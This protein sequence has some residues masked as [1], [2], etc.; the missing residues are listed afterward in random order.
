ESAVRVIMEA[1]GKTSR[2]LTEGL[3][4]L[5]RSGGAWQLAAAATP[6]FIR[7]RRVRFRSAGVGHGAVAQPAAALAPGN[8]P[9]RI[10]VH[11][12]ARE[13]VVDVAGL[14]AGHTSPLLLLINAE[15]PSESVAQ[16]LQRRA[17]GSL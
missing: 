4:A 7:G 15:D 14:P 10:A 2:V 3:E 16:A 17:D 5:P 9:A 12:R 13:I 11:G 6:E 8:P 1:P